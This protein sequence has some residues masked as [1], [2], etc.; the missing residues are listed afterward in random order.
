MGQTLEKRFQTLRRRIEGLRPRKGFETTYF[1]PLEE[2]LGCVPV[3]QW[4]TRIV[5]ELDF[6]LQMKAYAGTDVSEPVDA[7]L[8][9][10]EQ[11]YEKDGALP[12]SVCKKAE[13]CLMPLAKEAH[14]YQMIM[15]G[16]AHLD[17]NWKWGW[18]ETV[19]AVISTFRTMLRLMEEYPDFHFSQSQA[20]TY[21]IVEDHAPEMMPEIQKRIREGRWEVLASAWVETDKNMPCLESLQNQMLYAKKYMKET[22]GVDPETLDVDF[23]PDTFG[24]SAF[25]PE[26]DAL[27]GMKYY[28][29]CRGYQDLD[30]VLYRWRAPS[31]KELLMYKEPYWYSSTIMPA[32]AVGMP[33]LA[34]MSA[35]FRTAMLVYG[36]G[37]HGGGP[38]RRD[39]NRALWM[40]QWPVFPRLRFGRMR[41]YF[42]EAEA[43][44]E[45]LPVVEHELNAVFTGCYT[46]QSRIK[47]GNRRAETALL[48]AEKLSAL[49]ALELNGSYAEGAFE[50]AWRDTLFTH[51]HDILT[52]SCV[53]DSREHAMGLYQG[54]LG[55]ANTKAAGAL[56]TLAASIDTSAMTQEDEEFSRAFGA[57]VGYG[58][59]QGNIP[60][61]ETGTG[62][63]RI[64]HIVNTTSVDREEN[65]KLTVWDWPG[66]LKL[67]ETS[68]EDGNVLPCECISGQ[69]IFWSHRFFELL[70]TVKVP[71]HGYTTVVLREKSPEQETD[72]FIFSKPHSHQHMPIEDI[73][74]ENEYLTA[75]FDARSGELY[76]FVDKV[77]GEERLRHGETA[78]LRYITAQKNNESSWIIGRYVG[79]EKVK[80]LVK[81]EPIGGQLQS[82]FQMKQYVAGSEVNTTITL[83]NKDKFLKVQMQVDWKEDSKDKEEQ[84][85]LSYCLPLA[86][87]TGRMLC[88]VPGGVVWRPD[89]EL[90]MPC[91]RYAAA[92]LSDERVLALASDCKHGFRLSRNDLFVTLI[93]TAEHPDPYP[94]RGIHELSL[95]ILPTSGEAI[96]LAKET[97]ICLNPLQYVANTPHD[98]I[99]PAKGKLLDTVGDTVVF[100]GVSLRD[101]WL[102][103]RMYEV[104]GMECPVTVTLNYDVVEAYMADLFGNQLDIPVTVEGQKVSMTIRPHMQGELRIK[105]NK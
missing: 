22:W 52:G 26:L 69:Q 2:E 95:F 62:M 94:E 10:L 92:E 77:S 105:K 34:T 7:A 53:Q 63:T 87:S 67:V 99:L 83:G 90:D 59:G 17:M 102:A 9:I 55:I 32:A 72:S 3:N 29:H 85:I 13:E 100:R 37:N 74:L 24:H 44:R 98:G 84:P 61:H 4:H 31:G 96:T 89:Q 43:V 1:I 82:G 97:D 16:H 65:A 64:F 54:V 76:S 50:K 56:E 21:K 57:G 41:D 48:N 23:A 79:M 66:N 18:D 70:V 5:F 28:Y 14:T 40:Q 6:C 60:A 93:N 33:R 78:G 19:A 35:G 42:L 91:Q 81:L 8:T 45:Q 27:G 58:L 80:G 49:A 46:T 103:L 30:K 101:G 88:D 11:A 75:R 15:V 20:S 68:D 47:R 71:A 36:V 104:E 86:D 51:F 38:T 25:L 39:L 73:V 12:D